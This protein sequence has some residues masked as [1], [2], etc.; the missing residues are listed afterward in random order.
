MKPT[1]GLGETFQYSNALV[2]AGGYAAAHSTQPKG[3]L[4]TAYSAAMERL[5]FRPLGMRNTTFD[6]KRAAKREHVT[7]HGFDV[8]LETHALPLEYE[9]AVG[10]VAPAGGAW[11][12]ARDL[13]RYVQLE[14]AKGVGPDGKRLLSE[15][16][17]LSRREPQTK[18]NDKAS[19]GL[20]LFLAKDR[21]LEIISHGGNTLGMTADVFFIPEANVGAV[22]LTNSQAANAF[23]GAIRNR[24]LELWFDARP[25]AADGIAFA[26]EQRKTAL[27]KERE[28]LKLPPDAA[29]MA[30]FVGTWHQAALGA[31]T[32]R[33]EG[34]RF[35]ADAG[36][37]KSA[38]GEYVDVDGA[39]MLYLVDP[40]LIGLTFMPR[41]QDGQPA[42][43]LETEQQKYA[44]T[45][46]APARA[47]H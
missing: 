47:A 13:A 45:R 9:R 38:I 28:R 29:W 32:I 1:T 42:L 26:V 34:K 7:P 10:S 44:F 2:S 4:E 30:Q 40:P 25:R 31:L 43:V 39:R 21:K 15:A 12:T 23:T 41:D 17:L 33:A 27:A 19:Y 6:F 36:E 24:L 20:A 35:V 3:P 46:A 37:W 8:A 5:V 18:V 22:V 16:A 14:L 11:S